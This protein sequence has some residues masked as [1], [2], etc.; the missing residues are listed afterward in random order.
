MEIDRFCRQFFGWIF[1]LDF[2]IFVNFSLFFFSSS[3]FNE[4]LGK[5][6]FLS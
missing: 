2:F 1:V 4:D 6:S 3:S 5:D